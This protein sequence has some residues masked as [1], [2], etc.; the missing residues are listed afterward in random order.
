MPGF[1]RQNAV[2]VVG[3]ICA[4]L[5]ITFFSTFLKPTTRSTSSAQPPAINQTPN[6][7]NA[8][9]LI[10]LD[11]GGKSLPSDSDPRIKKAQVALTYLVNKTGRTETEIAAIVDKAVGEAA[12]KYGV[13]VTRLEFL[14]KCVS[15]EKTVA[16]NESGRADLAFIVAFVLTSYSMK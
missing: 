14:E 1:K 11:D 4:F 13:S 7:Q 3:L 5:L 16:K 8:A 2:I 10:A 12:T 6:Q 15:A 9:F